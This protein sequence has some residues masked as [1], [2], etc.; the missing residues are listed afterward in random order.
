MPFTFPLARRVG[1]PLESPPALFVQT[2]GPFTCTL[3]FQPS[4]HAISMWCCPRMG[5]LELCLPCCGYTLLLHTFT[6]SPKD[7]LECDDQMLHHL[8][9]LI[10]S[11]GQVE[12]PKPTCQMPLTHRNS[13]SNYWSAFV[14]V[15]IIC[16]SACGCVQTLPTLYI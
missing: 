5:E 15:T 2:A 11:V 3:A 16:K 7:F 10:P 8:P 14:Q 9:L 12:L 4:I 13:P 6:C 1:D